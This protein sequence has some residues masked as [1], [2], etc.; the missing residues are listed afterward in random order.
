MQ[1]SEL[2][3]ANGNRQIAVRLQSVSG[4]PIVG[5]TGDAKL[6]HHARA[7]EVQR[8]P[9]VMQESG[10]YVGTA[11]MA[12]DGVWQLELD[13]HGVGDDRFVSSQVIEVASDSL[14]V[15]PVG[16]DPVGAVQ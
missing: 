5:V 12:R 11:P 7:N 6:Y 13:L 4:L 14:G 3:D 15:D 8:V 16:A 2:P 10:L 9:L 1:V